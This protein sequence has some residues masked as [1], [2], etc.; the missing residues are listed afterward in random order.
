MKKNTI[1][2]EKI[3]LHAIYDPNTRKLHCKSSVGEYTYENVTTH[4]QIDEMLLDFKN[5]CYYYETK[6]NCKNMVNNDKC[7]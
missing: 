7:K 2:N 3:E 6:E 1:C 4:E 5:E